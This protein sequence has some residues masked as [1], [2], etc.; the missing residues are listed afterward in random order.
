MILEKPPRPVSPENLAGETVLVVRSEFSFQRELAPAARELSRLRPQRALLALIVDWAIIASCFG[1]ALQLPHP[2]VW[3]AA[4]IIIASRQ[5]A[6]LI[7]MHE[8]AH[9]RLL[10]SSG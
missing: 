4:A 7:L 8:A 2:L 5:H 6:L 9:Y 10:A 3:L 1:L